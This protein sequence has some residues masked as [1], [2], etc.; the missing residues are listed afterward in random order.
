MTPPHSATLV[1]EQPA[2][3]L[4]FS[5]MVLLAEND[6]TLRELS[7]ETLELDHFR[8]LSATDGQEALALAESWMPD[9]LVTDVAMPRLDGVGLIRAIRRL[10]PGMPVII[11]SGDPF[12]GERPL[13]AVAAEFDVKATLMKPFDL[14]DLS[15]AARK[16]VPLHTDSALARGFRSGSQSNGG[17]TAA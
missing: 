11:T 9:L 4:D 12:Y 5:P 15:L 6:R 16:V 10:Y 17:E 2:S 7:Q 13:A 8:V 3:S 14:A 1:P